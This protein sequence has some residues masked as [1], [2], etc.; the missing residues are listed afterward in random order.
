MVISLKPKLHIEAIVATDSNGAIGANNTLPWSLPT[1]LARFKRIT[2]GYPILM[3]TATALSVGR[4][5]PGR[6]NL[7]MTR[8]GQAPYEKQVPVSSIHDAIQFVNRL[9]DMRDLEPE[10]RKLFVIGGEQIY[11]ESLPYLTGLHLTTVDVTVDH[12]DRFFPVREFYDMHV[13]TGRTV[14]VKSFTADHP[15]NGLYHNYAQYAIGAEGSAPQI[16]HGADGGLMWPE[17]A[18]HLS[19]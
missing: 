1:D 8:T 14:K 18:D 3:G 16:A 13:R 11:R 6:T 10:E 4:S 15:E 9:Y 5:L 12:A 7:V 17:L 19:R 2:L